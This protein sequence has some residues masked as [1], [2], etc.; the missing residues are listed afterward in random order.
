[1]IE[2]HSE[3][4]IRKSQLLGLEK[5]YF[6]NQTL[7]TNP[8]KVFYFTLDDGPYEM[9]YTAQGRF[10]RDFNEGFYDEASRI[11]LKAI[12]LARK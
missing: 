2:T 6:G 10:D 4:L 7:N 5:Q 12:K 11:N 9:K 3:Y 1:V 8:F